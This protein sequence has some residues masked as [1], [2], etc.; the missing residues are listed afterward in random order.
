MKQKLL[1]YI[2][3][4]FMLWNVSQVYSQVDF[5]SDETVITPQTWSFMKYGNTP[6][7]L[8]TGSISVSVPIYDYH[9][10]D[11]DLPISLSYASGG[12][13]PNNQTGI[14]GLGWFLNT[15]GSITRQIKNMPDEDRQIIYG[16]LAANG[17]FYYHRNVVVDEKVPYIQR[18][19]SI[20]N[21][22]SL[23]QSFFY[24]SN[25]SDIS[26]SKY[27]TEPDVFYFNFMGYRGKF[28][29]G[30]NRSIQ[31]YNVE[32]GSKA[33]FKIT[34]SDFDNPT[35]SCFT[36]ATNDGYQY[37][38]GGEK[39]LY[40]RE[41]MSNADMLKMNVVS[42]QLTHIIAPNGRKISFKYQSGDAA[43]RGWVRSLH[44]STRYW[45]T[46]DGQAST[47]HSTS[48]QTINTFPVYLEKIV[49]DNS[50]QISL[51]YTPK[52][53]E[54]WG[55]E[56]FRAISYLPALQKLSSIVVQPYSASG[57]QEIVKCNFSYQYGNGNKILFLTKADFGKKGCYEMDYNGLSS[58]RFPPNGI[59][60]MDH[61]GYYNGK[62]NLSPVAFI[63]ITEHETDSKEVIIGSG[64]EPNEK[65]SSLGM[66]CELKYPT[67]GYTK[68]EYEGHR[69][70][71]KA[72]DL[73]SFVE[74]SFNQ[75]TPISN[76]LLAGGVRI[77]KITDFSD[78]KLCS[79]REF[80]Y[81]NA[82]KSSSGILLSMPHYRLEYQVERQGIL[83]NE[84][85]G[86]VQTLSS[87]SLDGMHIG[88]SR[89]LEK[90]SE[91]GS[92]EYNYS[93]YEN[94]YDE[95]PKIDPLMGDWH[96][97]Q[98][99]KII[100]NNA[101]AVRNLLATPM[102]RAINRGRLISKKYQDTGFNL[103]KE[104]YSYFVSRKLFEG[105]Y[106]C[107]IKSAGDVY[108]EM[109]TS[110]ED[111]PLMT[112]KVTSKLARRPLVVT[113]EN[114][115]YN[116][117]SKLIKI[118]KKLENGKVISERRE[119][120]EDMDNLSDAEQLMLDN[121]Q[122]RQPIKTV[123]TVQQSSKAKEFVLKGDY[124]IYSKYGNHIKL[125]NIKETEYATPM[126][127]RNFNLDY[128]YSAMHNDSYNSY[129]YLVQQT[130]QKGL[131]V[132]YIWGYNY[133][134]LVAVVRNANISEVEA[135]VGDLDI[136]ASSALPDFDKIKLL[137]QTLEK[138]HVV[139]YA[140]KPLVGMTEMTDASGVTTYYEY[141]SGGRL[142]CVRGNDKRIT[143]RYQYHYAVQ[144]N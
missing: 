91:C 40:D 81:E 106:V 126:E 92:I 94:Y 104:E 85:S 136:F 143:N 61:W 116:S 60:G 42:W 73:H 88:Y 28:Q 132:T 64:R 100:S 43:D 24:L 90:R 20:Q 137:R 97:M 141:D 55:R 124:H 110:L 35:R 118:A 29:F 112:K 109:K 83:E 138:A 3:V 27:E 11:F 120:L 140:Y 32:N 21:P 98:K 111:S 128:A 102:S 93:D 95:F 113:E 119:Y 36:I 44:P 56:S 9:D 10:N 75:P 54:S 135:I 48:I 86:I 77:K 129:G 70:S 16:S 5:Y 7:D 68:F 99:V 105:A 96:F 89:V 87:T 45:G 76:G 117:F 122:T 78:G 82:D 47:N 13:I 53:A 12:F 2:L 52:E 80:I 125:E 71:K 115:S 51:N 101:W 127:W 19:V 23:N 30:I 18:G 26:S 8:Y 31:I 41:M 65:S 58:E 123:L 66:L 46:I 130:D 39:T 1:R 74:F 108:Y 6:V 37:V 103:Y 84:Y 49:I 133:Q 38:F 59:Y 14:L 67:G 72:S 15:G 25:P 34:Y 63:P 107:N 142:S 79:R 69:Y 22:K 57:A 131:T 144:P 139:S 134:Y 121:F 4:S 17:Y 50:C 33:D 62:P 114:Y